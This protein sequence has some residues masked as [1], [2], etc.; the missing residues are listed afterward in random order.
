[1]LRN[2]VSAAVLASVVYSPRA[3]SRW[4]GKWA[5]LIA[6]LPGNFHTLLAAVVD[7]N[8][9]LVGSGAVGFDEQPS[10]EQI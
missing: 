6:G 3:L 5:S 4:P 10:A 2:S 7:D 8:D 1:M 9:L